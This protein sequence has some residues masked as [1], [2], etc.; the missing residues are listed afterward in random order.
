VHGAWRMMHGAWFKF[1]FVSLCM[2]PWCTHAQ[3][4]G[5]CAQWIGHMVHGAIVLSAV[6]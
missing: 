6:L 5:A 2:V 1:D 3:I 4:H